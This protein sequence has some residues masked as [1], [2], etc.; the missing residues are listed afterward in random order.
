[1]TFRSTPMLSV[2][3]TIYRKSL[4]ESDSALS[5]VVCFEDF[6][7]GNQAS[8]FEIAFRFLQCRFHYAGLLISDRLTYR[9]F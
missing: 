2:S 1:M 4:P 6:D 3:Q 7:L 9:R 5:R 8:V